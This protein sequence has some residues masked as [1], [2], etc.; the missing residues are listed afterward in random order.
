MTKEEQSNLFNVFSKLEAVGELDKLISE[1]KKELE[2]L[3]KPKLLSESL[4]Y[5]IASKRDESDLIYEARCD[6]LPSRTL[7]INN[8]TAPSPLKESDISITKHIIDEDLYG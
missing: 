7:D 5:H 1:K 3:E 4:L 8:V 6:R 2:R